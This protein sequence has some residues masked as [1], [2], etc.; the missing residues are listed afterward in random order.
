M[1]KI[2]KENKN[3]RKIQK[4]AFSLVELSIVMVIIAIFISGIMYA[5]VGVSNNAKIVVTKNRIDEIYKAFGNYLAVNHALP[6]PAPITSTKGSTNYGNSQANG[7]GKCWDIATNTAVVSGVYTSSDLLYGMIPIQNLNLST[8]MAEDGFGSKFAYIVNRKFTGFNENGSS[9]YN[10]NNAPDT[11]VITIKEG[12]SGTATT[13]TADAVFAIIS[14]GPNKFGAYKNTASTQ[15][16]RSSDADEKENDLNATVYDNVLI[17]AADRSDVFDDIV[18][19]KTK[20]NIMV[21]FELFSLVK[22]KP[23]GTN[24]GDVY[25]DSGNT[26]VATW[27]ETSYGQ[28]A[29]SSNKCENSSYDQTVTYPTKKCGAFGVW[30]AGAVDYC[31]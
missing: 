5:A 23:T 12:I 16:S 28:I 17:S 3:Q 6:C 24:N 22:C 21:D 2:H 31:Q 14:Y 20:K 10:F 9:T 15:N 8:E 7:L 1:K 29:I 18:F 26:H 19:Y 4:A 11:S 30:N 13:I 25:T 27:L